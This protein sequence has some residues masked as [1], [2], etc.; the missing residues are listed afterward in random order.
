MTAPEEGKRLV[1]RLTKRQGIPFAR[2]VLAPLP[3]VSEAA[4][5]AV[6]ASSPRVGSNPLLR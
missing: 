2:R 4:E 6:T 5:D 3:A 1:E